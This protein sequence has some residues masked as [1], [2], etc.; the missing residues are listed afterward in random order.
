M[1]ISSNVFIRVDKASMSFGQTEA[2]KEVSLEVEKGSIFGLVGSDGAGKSTLL[3]MIATMIKPTSGT[4]FVRW[5][6]RG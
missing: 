1:P 3:R 6:R 2:V 4:I 5:H